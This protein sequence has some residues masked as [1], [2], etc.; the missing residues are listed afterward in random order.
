[1]PQ[2]PHPF[3]LSLSKDARHDSGY[4]TSALGKCQRVAF[5]R[6]RL[7]GVGCSPSPTARM[8]LAPSARGLSPEA[9]PRRL[10]PPPKKMK[11]LPLFA[12]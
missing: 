8:A 3:V 4:A 10:K 11:S 7:N 1:M 6:L 9:V 2:V 5:D 12:I